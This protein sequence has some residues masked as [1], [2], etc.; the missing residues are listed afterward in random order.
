[1]NW[2]EKPLSFGEILDVTFKIVKKNFG[3]LLLILL[4]LIGPLYILQL[5]AMISGGSAI[6]QDPS[7]GLRFWEN[8]DG[9]EGI[10]DPFAGYGTIQM[11]LY[12]I[13]SILLGLLAAPVAYGALIIAVDQIRRA[14]RVEVG[15][16][17][18]KAFSR[19]GA[20]LGGI[21]VTSLIFLAIFA[22]IT[23]IFVVYVLVAIGPGVM[24][25]GDF[26][27]PVSGTPI[28]VMILLG[29]VSF[30]VFV[31][32]LTRWSFFFPAIVFEKVSPGLGKSW[33]LTRNNFWRLVGLYIVIVIITSIL[34]AIFQYIPVLILGSSLLTTV[35]SDAIA[36]IIT[37]ISA[38]AYAVI[39][40]DLRIRNEAAD[41]KEI[42][43]SFE[44]N[45][46]QS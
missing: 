16:S 17:I 44:D 24:S 1:M 22:V 43:A 36:L 3:K 30:V 4:V 18:R 33:R 31:Y 2:V 29:L 11:A 38:T 20:L 8:T 41:L 39:Y 21:I 12:I 7:A 40:F 46:G 5:I 35:I 32:L 15:D 9:I 28:F 13:S 45:N 34:S 6:V 42:V 37:L 14:D 25:G 19:Y 23:I 10:A 27:P 26:F